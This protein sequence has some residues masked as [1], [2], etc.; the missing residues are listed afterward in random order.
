MAQLPLGGPSSSVGSADARPIFLVDA[1]EL[2]SSPASALDRDASRHSLGSPE[3][4]LEC[5]NLISKRRPEARVL[6][7]LESA[8]YAHLVSS[9]Q[10]SGAGAA[11]SSTFQCVPFGCEAST[12]CLEFASRRAEGG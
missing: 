2:Y 10:S 12:F 4:V 8:G 9:C 11:A 5:C 6:A 1:G 7:F 3:R